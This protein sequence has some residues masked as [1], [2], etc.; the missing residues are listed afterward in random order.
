MRSQRHLRETRG[1]DSRD[2]VF[3]PGPGVAITAAGL[4]TATATLTVTGT[5]QRNA[6][7]A[8]RRLAS[9]GAEFQAPKV[10]IADNAAQNT[11]A[12]AI[13]TALN[14][15][16]DAASTVT[17]VAAVATNVVTLT[18]QGGGT[19]DTGLVIDIQ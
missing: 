12:T 2:G 15:I 17:L 3:Y 10:A 14:G 16:T 11:I 9:G 5:A 1:V 8:L 7:L 13:R 19:I 18:V 6:N 4:G